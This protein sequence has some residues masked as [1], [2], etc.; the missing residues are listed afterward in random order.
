MRLKVASDRPE[1]DVIR[2]AVLSLGRGGVIAYPTETFYGLAVS[3]F[4]LEGCRRVFEIKG[5]PRS[6]ALPLIL[7]N[8]SQLAD[9]AVAPSALMQRLAEKFWP[10]PL[11][12]VV[13][14]LP[15]VAAA[16]ED[17]TV[18]LRISSLAVARALASAA[19]PVTSTSANV[20]GSPPA[21]TAEEVEAGLGE[22]IDVVLDGGATS[23]GR[24]STIVDI[25]GS[26]PKLVR[27]G[28]IGFADVLALVENDGIDGK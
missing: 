3:A 20:S 1:P 28:R 8:A 21:M 2:R 15:V 26:T 22:L 19:G 11:T 6:R 24:A 9:V 10:G 4:D 23:G 7:A 5:R 16:S 25:T 12:L 13:E 18:A 27:E 14:A 17:G